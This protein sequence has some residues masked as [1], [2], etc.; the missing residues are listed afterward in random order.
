MKIIF[1]FLYFIFFEISQ[2]I[3][4]FFRPKK[5]IENIEEKFLKSNKLLW[6]QIIDQNKIKLNNEFILITNIVALP[7]YAVL[8]GTLGKY[9]SIIKK[10]KI[11]G[12]VRFNDNQGSKIFES[13][14][15][16]KV[17]ELRPASF[18]KKIFYFLKSILILKRIKTVEKF[19]KFKHNN[20]NIGISVY[21]HL[22]RYAKKGSEDKINF[23]FYYHLS[24]A[25]YYDDFSKRIFDKF[26]IKL[27]IMS[28]TQFIPSSIIFENA[29]MRNIKV[30]ATLGGSNMVTVR[31][32]KNF[33][34]RFTLRPSISD[35]LFKLIK[36][37]YRAKAIRLG[38]LAITNRFEGKS[39]QDI[40]DSKIAY[41]DKTHI[42]KNELCK[43]YS[44][45]PKKNVVC[46]FAHDLTDGNY[47]GSWRL[48]K[49]NLTWLRQIL[50]HIRSIDN[51]NW[52]IKDHPSDRNDNTETTTEKEFIKLANGCGHIA[53]FDNKYNSASIKNIASYILTSQG[54]AGAEYPCF[55]I[56]SILAG[57]SHYSNFGF[58]I[59]PKSKKQFFYY[60]K[61]LNKKKF[62]S[63]TKKQVNNALI[64]N[65]ILSK[66]IRIKIPL[67][68]EFDTS[69]KLNKEKF[70][71]DL[72]QNIKN[73][74]FKND[75][76]YKMLNNQ[77]LRNDRHLINWK[78]LH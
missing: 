9:I 43:L 21:D 13:Y 17:L 71:Q 57:D 14:G 25:L 16:K 8:M 67:I 33:S 66:L 38:K 29:L 23:K 58:T 11:L 18:I 56:P 47:L 15:S 76:F 34:E 30:A 77:I 75:Y 24:E 60:L 63:L 19:I 51:V 53:F 37:K 69:R 55:G 26:K 68:S 73:Y 5:I 74:K 54:S 61:K 72:I 40:R 20:L 28:E 62:F 4:F 6:E 1:Y 3:I 52:L 7:S 70:Y 35:N 39:N 46:I 59:E 22:I 32:W 36:K 78:I 64:Y 31:I 49:D 27:V 10:Y 45:D 48:F 65:F 2:K 50:I 41:K 12:L 42:S 44:W